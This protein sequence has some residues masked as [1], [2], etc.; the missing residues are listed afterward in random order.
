[1]PKVVDHD[2][3]RA[4]FARAAWQ[5]IVRHGLEK[6]TVRAVADAA[7]C[8]TGRLVHYFDSK[9][10]LLVHAVKHAR[11]DLTHR[12]AQCRRGKDGLE[13]LRA[14]LLETLPSS[15][16]RR[17][18]WRF[19]F[20]FWGQASGHPRLVREQRRSHQGFFETVRECLM[21][22]QELGE[23]SDRMD[24][25]REVT[26]IVSLIDGLGVLGTF[27]P[28]LHPPKSQIDQVDYCLERLSTGW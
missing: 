28:R 26:M 20:V 5:T 2:E 23:I 4:E 8:S 21:R 11:R 6:T 16:Q 17:S 3:S 24:L 10:D 12:F 14:V 9:E 13:A 18:E 25:E 19:W 7:G 1:M 15:A 22:A 27:T